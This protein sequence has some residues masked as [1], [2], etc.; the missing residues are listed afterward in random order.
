MKKYFVMLNTY[1][2]TPALL[3]DAEEDEEG[4]WCATL[5]D[6]KEEAEQAGIANTLGRSCGFSVYCWDTDKVVF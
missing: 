1:Q 3:N 5:F 6:T 4:S 2:S